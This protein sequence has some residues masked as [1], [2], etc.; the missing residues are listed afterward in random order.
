ME[1][2]HQFDRSRLAVEILF[3]T[4]MSELKLLPEIEEPRIDLTDWAI[5]IGVGALFILVGLDKFPNESSSFWVKMFR[6]IGL[7][8]W[9]R[10]TAG[11]VEIVGGLLVLIPRFAFI[12]GLLL[13]ATMGVALLVHV[14]ILG[15]N[16]LPI[17]LLFVVA[18]AAFTRQ[19]YGRRKRKSVA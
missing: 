6:Q 14:F 19:Q 13:T 16:D 18:L 4:H 10:Y 12:S 11:I 9:F 5:R 15:D 8:D 17:S 3:R 2:D 1:I 7:G